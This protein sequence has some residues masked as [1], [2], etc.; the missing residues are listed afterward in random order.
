MPGNLGDTEGFPG[1]LGK[2]PPNEVVSRTAFANASSDGHNC[3]SPRNAVLNYFVL[4]PESFRREWDLSA[5][6]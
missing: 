6:G 4:T 1:I 3:A 2:H 5:K